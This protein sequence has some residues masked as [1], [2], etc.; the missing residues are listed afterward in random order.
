[1]V[2]LLNTNLYI[3]AMTDLHLI[4]YQDWAVVHATQTVHY[5]NFGWDRKF[6][7]PNKNHPNYIYYEEGNRLS[8]NWVDGEAHLFN[9]SGTETF[10]KVLNFIDK[11]I[12]TKKV[13]I[14]CDQGQSRSPTLGLL[15][16][17]KRA[18]LIPYQS[19]ELA[20]TEFIKI[21]PHY[22]PSGIA[23]YVK[24]KWDEMY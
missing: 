17:A 9:W 1:M 3:G 11:W 18:K 16:L 12:Q 4:N 8:L 6:N 14:H 19:F 5:E 22:S 15:Y 10:I 13:L 20:R 2:K 21:Y 7:K 24:H 23:D